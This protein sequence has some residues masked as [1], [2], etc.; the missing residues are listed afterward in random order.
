M[1]S[2]ATSHQRQGA[3]RARLAV[4]FPLWESESPAPF[5]TSLESCI[6]PGSEK[7]RVA[8]QIHIK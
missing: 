8:V 5:S 1:F 4:D 7:P 3:P 2:G 6:Q